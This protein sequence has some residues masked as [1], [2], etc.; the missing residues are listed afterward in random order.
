MIQRSD[1]QQ[2][3]RGFLMGGADIIPGVSGG[4]VALILGIYNRLVR[5]VSRFDLTL[6]GYLRHRQWK[7]AAAYVDLRFLITLGIGIATGIIGLASLM[8]HLLEDQEHLTIHSLQAEQQTVRLNVGTTHGGLAVGTICTVFRKNEDTNRFDEIATLR[9]EK[10]EGDFNETETVRI[11]IAKR[12][13]SKEELGKNKQKNIEPD[14]TVTHQSTRRQFTLAAFFGMILASGFLVAQM[15]AS[16]TWYRAVAVMIGGIASFLLV[17][18]FPVAPMDGDLYLF[19]CGMIAI[20]AMILPGLSGAFILLVLGVYADVT[21][22]LRMILHRE[23][24]PEM[25]VSVA[26]F[27]LGCAVGLLSFSKLL[28]R[29]LRRHEQTTMTV[30]CGVM[31]GSLRKIWPFKHDL[32]PDTVGFSKKFFENKWP[33]SFDQQTIITIG[34]MLVSAIAIIL[35]D[36]ITAEHDQHSLQDDR[37]QNEKKN[38]E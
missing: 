37:P 8:H 30:L 33:D 7:T 25:F 24:D 1:L 9:I 29:L 36:R 35:L 14:D 4:T 5:A 20:C 15:I 19:L 17:G 18:L 32:T 38:H 11:A 2:I 13:D 31:L 28:N 22:L 27:I 34:I 16:W 10:F 26:I 6:F 21:G 12:I 3:G 23:A